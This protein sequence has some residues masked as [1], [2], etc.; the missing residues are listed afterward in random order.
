MQHKNNMSA[1]EATLRDLRSS[2]ELFGGV[3]VVFGGDFAQTLPVVVRGERP[4][5][6]EACLQ[7]SPFWHCLQQLYLTENM[8]LQPG[9]ANSRW[10]EWIRDMSYNS[11]LHG[12]IQLPP[13]IIH[14]FDD[15]A[16]FLAHMFPPHELSELS[17]PAQMV[18]FFHGRGVLAPHNESANVTSQT[19]TGQ[20]PSPEEEPLHSV[21]SVD[22][23]DDSTIHALSAEFLASLNPNSLPFSALKLRVGVPVMLLRN[24]NRSAGLC[25][26]TR[27]IVLRISRNCIMIQIMGGDFHGRQGFIPRMMLNSNKA[28]LNWIVTRR[29]F[30]LRVCFAFTVNKSQGQ[31][32]TKV[33]IDLR[34]P[35]FSH[36]QLYVA[37]SRATDVG[38][39][40]VLFDKENA[41]QRTMN[42]VYPEVLLRS[43]TLGPAVQPQSEHGGEHGGDEYGWED[44]W[45]VD[46]SAELLNSFT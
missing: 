42:V 41:E 30:P 29:Q 7:K 39:I 38:N 2:D 43:D 1:V 35:C 21:D 22:V 19:V 37:L 40:A 31:S 8:R 26:G 11:Q 27:G 9:P 32:L 4:Q 33:G 15:E 28:E 46:Y 13:E 23:N 20:M 16:A 18:D 6:V 25:N 14:R 12:S 24:L 45:D 3:P 10:A 36:G 34:S 5:I 44:D 17:E